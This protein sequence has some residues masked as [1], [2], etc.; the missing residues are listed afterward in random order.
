M[1]DWVVFLSESTIS[2]HRLHSLVCGVP[3]ITS[4][5][6]WD[7]LLLVISTTALYAVCQLLLVTSK[8]WDYLLLVTSNGTNILPLYPQMTAF[9]GL[10][11]VYLATEGSIISLAGLTES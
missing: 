5:K 7:Y 2:T 9:S 10:G 8:Y 3:T 4:N 11:W 6:Y 1:N